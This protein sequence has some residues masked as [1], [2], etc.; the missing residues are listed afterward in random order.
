MFINLIIYCFLIVQKERNLFSADAYMCSKSW[1][2]FDASQNA[3]RLN[4]ACSFCSS[5][6]R[7]SQITLLFRTERSTRVCCTI[8]FIKQNLWKYST[9]KKL[10]QK[11]HFWK[12]A[13]ILLLDSAPKRDIWDWPVKHDVSIKFHSSKRFLSLTVGLARDHFVISRSY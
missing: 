3:R 1:P 4:R 9:I 5:I 11:G 12:A 7:V 10:R 2:W 13:G 6:N 8:I